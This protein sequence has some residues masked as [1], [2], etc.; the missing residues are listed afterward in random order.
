MVDKLNVIHICDKFGMRGSTIHGVSRLF[1]WWFPRFDRSRYNV[2]LY[3]VKHPDTASRSLE[4]DG[5]EM[6]YMG[7]SAMNPSTLNAFINIARK[8]KADV[9]HLHGWIAANYGRIAGKITGIPTIMHEHGVDP[10]FPRT[11][12]IADMMLS[13]FT[14]S[15]VAVS[16]SVHDFLIKERYVD[17]KKIRTIYNGAPLDEFSIADQQKVDAARK[18]F[19]IPEGSRVIGTIGRLDVQKGITYFIQAA[20]QVKSVM[21]DVRYLIV[22]DGPKMDELQSEARELNMLDTMI[23]A[24]HRTDV[25]V[26]QSMLDLQVFPSLWEGTPLTVFEAMAMER[27]IVST[28]VDGLGEVLVDGKNALVV[29]PANPDKLA[30]GILQVLSDPALAADLRAGSKEQ[31]RSFDISQTVRNLESLYEELCPNGR[32]R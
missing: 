19:G 7:K 10:Q 5:V 18:E 3:A 11:Q 31:S 29:E 22:G 32:K 28:N 15:A 16:R 17:P 2:K 14:H 6:T 30:K 23:F 9:L 21:P 26:I 8:E 25:P 1:A 20:K 4:S 27:A 12:Q 13:R 24:G